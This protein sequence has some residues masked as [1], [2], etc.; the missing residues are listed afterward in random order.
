MSKQTVVILVGIPGSGKTH[1][2]TNVI[3]N[4]FRVSQ[5]DLGSK[6][7]C[8][9]AF[10]I[11][12]KAGKSVVVDRCNF[13]RKQRK[14]WISLANKLGVQN[15]EAVTF[16]TPMDECKKR[17]LQRKNHPTLNNNLSDSKKKEVVEWFNKMYEEPT[18]GEGFKMITK[19]NGE[20]KNELIQKVNDDTD[21]ELFDAVGNFVLKLEE[22]KEPEL[23]TTYS[24]GNSVWLVTAKKSEGR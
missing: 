9:N 21:N 14:E 12:I 19:F 10:T 6:K 7:E 16:N 1:Y 13:N 4:H 15:I 24:I 17:V 23:T 11:A 8:I 3:K 5:D 20:H 22:L 2:A 18:K